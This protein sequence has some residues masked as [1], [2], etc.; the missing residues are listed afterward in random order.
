MKGQPAK[1]YPLGLLADSGD[2][3]AGWDDTHSSKPIS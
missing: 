1:A 3:F 2:I